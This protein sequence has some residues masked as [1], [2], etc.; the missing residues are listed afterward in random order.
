MKKWFIPLIIFISSFMIYTNNVKA[1]T[2]SATK[3]YVDNQIVI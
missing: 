2:Y 3:H 1:A